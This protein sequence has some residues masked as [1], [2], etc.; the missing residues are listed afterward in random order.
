M[1]P[2]SAG[3]GTSWPASSPHEPSASTD[4]PS[5]R[6]AA[7]ASLQQAAA[8][9]PEAFVKVG[10]RKY[11]LTRH[12]P[13]GTS[14]TIWFAY[15]ANPDCTSQETID[16]RTTKEPEHGTVE[17]VPG[18]SRPH[19]KTPGGWGKVNWVPSLIVAGLERRIPRKRTVICGGSDAECREKLEAMRLPVIRSDDTSSSS[20]L[21]RAGKIDRDRRF[22][23]TVPELTTKE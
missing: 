5:C 18:R 2:P 8:Q 4:R 7:I 3:P 20:S 6:G 11:D 22:P 14:R 19:T 1:P 10:L 21:I 23:P 13:T 17:V 9:D 12:V 15:A 16:I